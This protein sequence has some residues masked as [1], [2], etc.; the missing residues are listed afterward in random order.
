MSRPK[1]MT[2]AVIVGHKSILKQTIEALYDTN[3]FHIEDF[4]EDESGF[5]IDKPFENAE[6]VSKKLVKIRS[7]S[8]YLGIA[9]N[10]PVVQKSGTVLRELDSKLDELDRGISEKTELIIRLENELK[11]LDSQKKELLPFLSINLDFDYFRGYESIKVFAG[12]IKGSLEESQVSSI[13]KAFELYVDPQSKSIVLFVANDDADRVYELI[14]SL[15]F[16]ELRVPERGGVPSETLRLIEQK[17][18]EIGKKIESTKAGI[19]S[20]KSKYADFILASDEVLS[21]E[22]EKAELPLKIATSA[23]AFIIDGWTPSEDY[24]TV[25]SAVNSATAGKA[26]I[27]KLEIE[28]EEEERVPVEY[29]NTDAADHGSVFQTQIHRT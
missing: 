13:T 7:I 6:A 8:N 12:T 29:N 5:K 22:S 9:S 16:R 19:D 15:G 17:E 3:L 23:N 25:V 28:E 20:M 1:V 11:D 24:D 27:S 14:Q 18:A 21:I 26:Y 10:E 2:R 4:V